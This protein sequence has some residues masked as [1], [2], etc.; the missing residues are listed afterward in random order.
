MREIKFR[1]WCKNKNEWEQ[2][3]IMLTPNGGICQLKNGVHIPCKPDTHIIQQSTGLKDKNGKEIYEGDIIRIY[4]HIFSPYNFIVEF[5]KA[6]HCWWFSGVEEDEFGMSKKSFSFSDLNGF[7]FDSE[8][9]GNIYKN[10]E[11]LK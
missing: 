8:I 9:I 3:L 11:L 5:S 2:D 6:N 7:N 1:V 10:P 4:E